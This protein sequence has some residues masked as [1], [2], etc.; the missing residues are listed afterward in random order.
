MLYN[1]NIGRHNAPMLSLLWYYD[2]GGYIMQEA[3]SQFEFEQITRNKLSGMSDRQINDAMTT[4]DR[5]I[6][7]LRK[8]GKDTKPLEVEYCYY[9][10]EIQRRSKYSIS[11]NNRIYGRGNS[12]RG[13]YKNNRK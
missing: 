11:L 12:S 1:I 13:N 5:Q 6:R 3:M 9:E 7:M 10:D 2:L 8:N 4:I